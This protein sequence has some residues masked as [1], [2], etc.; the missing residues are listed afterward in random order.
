MRTFIFILI[1]TL[2]NLQTF[3]F[4]KKQIVVNET[5]SF[6]RPDNQPNKDLSFK[7]EALVKGYSQYCFLSGYI[8]KHKDNEGLNTITFPEGTLK[9]TFTKIVDKELVQDEKGD[10]N[11]YLETMV[12]ARLPM[13]NSYMTVKCSFPTEERVGWLFKTRVLSSEVSVEP[14]GV[15]DLEDVFQGLFNFF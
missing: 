9:G 4:D 7:R 3:A 1:F 5:V 8:Y 6:I 12:V 15:E 2:I 10:G 14:P 13:F 11:Y